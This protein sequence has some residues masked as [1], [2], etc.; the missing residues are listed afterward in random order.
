MRPRIPAQHWSGRYPLSQTMTP[1]RTMTSNEKPRCWKLWTRKRTKKNPNRT[2]VGHAGD[3]RQLLSSGVREGWAGSGPRPRRITSS[4]SD[5]PCAAS[6]VPHG[7]QR[8][9]NPYSG[10]LSAR[11]IWAM[12]T[13]PKEENF[14]APMVWTD[15]CVL[16]LAAAGVYPKTRVW[17]S[18][19][20]TLPCLGA[21]AELRIELSWGCEKS[22]G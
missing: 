17:G 19:E 8:S 22:R 9:E 6:F 14:S 15:E 13:A 11:K 10:H 4:L 18:R 12:L 3:R 16:P 5:A 7:A 21:T 1:A 20:K 2:N